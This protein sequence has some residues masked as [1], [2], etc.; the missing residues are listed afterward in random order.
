MRQY[1]NTCNLYILLWVLYSLQGTLYA[2]G[3]IISQGILAILLLWS[4]YYCFVVNTKYYSRELPSFIK[5]V[6]IFLIMATIYGIILILSGKELYITEGEITKTSNL[7]YLKNVYISLLPLYSF[8][9]FSKRKLLIEEHIRVLIF[10][11]FVVAIISPIVNINNVVS[12]INK[13]II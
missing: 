6:N 7:D 1:L 9:E 13:S 4:I 3:S 8:Y 2:S 11:L 10:I 5:A 12:I